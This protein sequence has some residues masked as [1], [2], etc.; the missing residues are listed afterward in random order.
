VSFIIQVCES[1][2][3]THTIAQTAIERRCSYTVPP[4]YVLLH[5]A[6][7][8]VFCNS[9]LDLNTMSSDAVSRIGIAYSNWNQPHFTA[10]SVCTSLWTVSIDHSHDQISKLRRSIYGYVTRRCY[11]TYRKMT[12]ESI[13]WILQD[14]NDWV[15][16]I[17]RSG[18][19]YIKK[20]I[21]TT[22]RFPFVYAIMP[23]EYWNIHVIAVAHTLMKTQSDK[24]QF[25]RSTDYQLLVFLGLRK[26]LRALHWSLADGKRVLPL[27]MTLRLLKVW[28]AFLNNGF[29]KGTT[30]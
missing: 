30:R 3:T 19:T 7:F 28:D 14:Y 1:Y 12:S 17:K 26:H 16:G 6:L 4:W 24:Q 25:A 5:F 11:I 20:D 15:S 27:A 23:N 29:T 2:S 22:G 13:W 21:L 10:R 8:S 18:D 9:L